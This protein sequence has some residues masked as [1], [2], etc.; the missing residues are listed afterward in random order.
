[1]ASKEIASK[2]GKVAALFREEREAR[3]GAPRGKYPDQLWDKVARLSRAGVSNRDLCEHCGILSGTLSQGLGRAMARAEKAPRR[4]RPR[5][6]SLRVKSLEVEPPP[7]VVECGCE[8]V[9]PNGVC[10]RLP[11]RAL[12]EALIARLKAC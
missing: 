8:V 6:L 9:F 4:G 7:A 2:L 3:K 5:S 12:D 10:V 1:M 11:Y